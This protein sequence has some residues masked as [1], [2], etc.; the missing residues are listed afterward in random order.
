PR[1]AVAASGRQEGRGTDRLEWPLEAV[2][3]VPPRAGVGQ[4]IRED[5]DDR[6]RRGLLRRRP[7][8]TAAANG[9]QCEALKFAIAAD[10]KSNDIESILRRRVHVAKG[11]LQSWKSPMILRGKR[12]RGRIFCFSVLPH[13][14]PN[15]TI[16]RVF[17]AL[18]RRRPCGR[19]A[20]LP[21]PNSTQPSSSPAVRSYTNR[22]HLRPYVGHGMLRT[23]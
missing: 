12:T 19:A 6:H 3:P 17:A 4:N 21:H 13:T 10:Q 20:A 22:G 9:N 23:R 8:R 1:R 7:H 18:L 2:P 5:G 15:A 11:D 16:R 14:P